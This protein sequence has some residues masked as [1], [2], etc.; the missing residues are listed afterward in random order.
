MNLSWSR[1]FR[2]T[3]VVALFAAVSFNA[4]LAARNVAVTD[5]DGNLF[6]LKGRGDGTFN[7]PILVG[8]LSGRWSHGVCVGDFDRDGDLDIVSADTTGGVFIFVNDGT[9]AFTKTTAS[10]MGA[11]GICNDPFASADFNNDGWLDF[12]GSYHWEPST[13]SRK[14]EVFLNNRDGTFSRSSIPQSWADCTYGKAAGDFNEDGNKDFIVVGYHGSAVHLY[15]GNGDGTFVDTYP[16]RFPNTEAPCLMAA[17]FNRDG[18]LD[19]LGGNDDDGDA[20]QTWVALGNGDGTFAAPIEAFDL[21]PGAE[22][23][24]DNHVG[25]HGTAG[26]FND[27]GNPDVQIMDQYSH[28]LFFAEGNGDGT[29]CD[30]VE[31]EQFGSAPKGIGGGG[32]PTI[33]LFS[34]ATI[35][36]AMLCVGVM[37]WRRR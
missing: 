33:P 25:G 18:H 31:V 24:W 26:D 12:V 20:G 1:S 14:L 2:V 28:K 19:A 22:S 17:D 11:S 10:S 7:P 8:I 27:D 30:P 4:V 15:L 21:M 32:L 29:F 5:D 13:S 9:D 23:G 34:T 37:L 6:Y 35:P 36:L 16:F 3:F